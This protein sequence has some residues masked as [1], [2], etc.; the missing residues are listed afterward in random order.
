MAAG[1]AGKQP[2]SC[3]PDATMKKMRHILIKA[4]TVQAAERNKKEILI[5]NTDGRIQLANLLTKALPA[6]K[7]IYR[8]EMLSFMNQIE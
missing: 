8:S 4:A 5:V 3:S 6:E 7:F 1:L 2:K